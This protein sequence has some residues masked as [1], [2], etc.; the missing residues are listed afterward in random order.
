MVDRRT[1]TA[2]LP[3]ALRRLL[4]EAGS[5][6]IEFVA[7]RRVVTYADPVLVLRPDWF[8]AQGV[9]VVRD[10]GS[11]VL[12]S[13]GQYQYERCGELDDGGALYQRVT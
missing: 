7:G 12:D 13:D 11:V 5:A 1:V 10:D 6:G 3:P 2:V 8:D 4:L 9:D